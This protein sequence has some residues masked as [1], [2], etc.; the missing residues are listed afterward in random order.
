MRSIDE[1]ILH[2]SATKEGQ[3]IKADTIR[4]WHLKRGF[5][6]IGYHYVIDLDGTV[7]TGRPVAQVGAHT[8]GRNAHSIG[9]CYIGGVDSEGKPKDTRTE[10]QRNS[11]LGLVVSLVAL[12]GTISKVTGHRRY[13]NKACPSFDVGAWLA[14]NGLGRLD[15]GGIK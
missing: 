9:I 8:E 12:Y 7:E 15:P 5:K 2:C 14:E 4:R 3:D 6:D 11:M 13:A 10:K 1:I